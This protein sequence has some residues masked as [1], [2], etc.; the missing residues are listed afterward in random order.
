MSG[1]IQDIVPYWVAS[2]FR[3]RKKIVVNSFP[4]VWKTSS[5]FPFSNK[6]FKAWKYPIR[7]VFAQ[8]LTFLD[9]NWVINFSE[10]V[11]FLQCFPK[12][13]LKYDMFYWFEAWKSFPHLGILSF[14]PNLC[15]LDFQKGFCPP[16]FKKDEGGKRITPLP[17]FGLTAIEKGASLEDF[18]MHKLTCFARE[19]CLISWNFKQFNT[20]YCLYIYQF[21]VSNKEASD[22]TFWQDV[23][24]QQN[25]IRYELDKNRLF[26]S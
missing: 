6:T 13:C 4:R 8:K 3:F 2:P 22:M 24:F 26:T 10:K 21:L 16:L 18:I 14:A 12:K 9:K 19:Q 15:A 1:K 7:W 5:P 20:K 25:W 11:M 17:T 23:R